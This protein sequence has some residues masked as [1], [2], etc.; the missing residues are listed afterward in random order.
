[1]NGIYYCPKCQKEA[2]I[3]KDPRTKKYI[4][5]CPGCKIKQIKDI[6]TKKTLIDIYGKT[7][8]IRSLTLEELKTSYLSSKGFKTLKGLKDILILGMIVPLSQAKEKEKEIEDL[9]IKVIY[10]LAAEILK[11]TEES[12]APHFNPSER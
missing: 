5:Y 12:L 7:F 9:E 1:M 10:A 3:Q 8:N 2:K 11:L 6:E 4:I